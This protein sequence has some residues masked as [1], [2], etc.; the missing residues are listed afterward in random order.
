MLKAQLAPFSQDQNPESTK[1]DRV[2]DVFA[3]ASVNEVS[4][5][6]A[7]LPNKTSPLNYSHKLMLKSCSD[8]ITP[9]IVHL[10]N[11]SFTE[12]QF[13]DRFKVAQVTPLLKKDGLDANDPVN[14]R[15]ISNPNTISRLLRAYVSLG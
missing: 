6:I 15:S 10:A 4:K 14:Y 12:G 8:V 13:P 11:L 5:L 1:N 9:L 2:L 7:N 3:E